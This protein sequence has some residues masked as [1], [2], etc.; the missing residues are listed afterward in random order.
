MEDID[1]NDLK[2]ADVQ[3]SS[4]GVTGDYVLQLLNLQSQDVK[5]LRVVHTDGEVHILILLSP[6]TQECPI[7]G[8]KTRKIKE[9]TEKRIVHSIFPH[10]K[11][12]IIY[13]ARRYVCPACGKTFYEHNPFTFERSR[14]SVATVYNCLNE[15]RN[16]HLTFKDVAAMNGL[17]PQSVMRIFDSHVKIP[18][19]PLPEFLLIDE[20]Y[21]GTGNSSSYIC[22][23]IDYMTQMVVDILPSRKKDDLEAYFMLIPREERMKV[24]IVS[25][26]LWRTYRIVIRHCFPNAVVAA[27]HYHVIQELSRRMTDVRVDVMNRKSAL[28][29]TLPRNTQEWIQ[30]DND[31]YILKKFSWLLFKRFSDDTLDPNRAKKMNR[32][33]HRYLNYYDIMTMILDMDE[34]LC[35]AERLYDLTRRFYDYAGDFDEDVLTDKINALI[36][37][38]RSS[39]IGE[40]VHFAGTLNEWKVPVVNSFRM[41]GNGKRISNGLIES[42]NKVIKDLKHV[43]NGFHSFERMRNR[44]MFCLNPDTVF[45]MLPHTKEDN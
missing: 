26:D 14:I 35:E 42:K 21:A 4:A 17:S 25:T 6:R 30:A 31:Y 5:S 10:T 23:L 13:R 16:P 24:R 29:K 43:S 39:G 36:V 22:V 40:M 18:R 15:L 44:I 33:L 41:A 7:C 11:C 38:F 8:T 2:L 1:E 45:Y 37:E 28:R 34:D 32:K 12:Y 3:P 9:Y 19:R 27:D 20:V